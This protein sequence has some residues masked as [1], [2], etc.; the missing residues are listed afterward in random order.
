MGP[1]P[2]TLKRPCH[3][4]YVPPKSIRLTDKQAALRR[5]PHHNRN[6]ARG[7]TVSARH[8]LLVDSQRQSEEA[9]TAIGAY[10]DI[11]AGETDP[12]GAYIVLKC[13]YRH[14]AARAPNTSRTNMEKVRG[15]FQTLYQWE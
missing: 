1:I 4:L 3:P 11:E 12:R 2:P 6:V 10:L 14:V 9:A 8:Y 7:L 13:W 5:N 15:D